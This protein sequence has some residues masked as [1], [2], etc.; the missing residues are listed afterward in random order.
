[1]ATIDN[2]SVSYSRKVQLDQF[3]PVEHFVELDVSVE[4]D[5]D[6]EEVYD[7]YSD[8]AE[9]LVESAIVRRVAAKK[10]EDSDD[11]DE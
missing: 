7:E 2:I 9:G 11:E 1:M 3:E 6:I 8:Q 4:Q 5:E 10:L